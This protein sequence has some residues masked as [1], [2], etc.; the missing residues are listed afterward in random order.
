V[1]NVADDILVFG[2][3]E[4]YSEIARDHDVNLVA[5]L[6]RARERNLKLNPKKSKF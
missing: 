5:L 3:G 2:R 4:A 1:I 6:Q